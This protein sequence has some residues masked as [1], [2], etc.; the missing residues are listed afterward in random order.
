MYTAGMN[1]ID[2]TRRPWLDLWNPFTKENVTREELLRI[3]G[4]VLQIVFRTPGIY[5]L[6][7]L[8]YHYSHGIA[9]SADVVL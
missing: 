2:K 3:Y 1:D 6:P 7:T 9:F 5:K 8:L 4:S